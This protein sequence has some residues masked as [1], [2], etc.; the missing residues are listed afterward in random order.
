MGGN[1]CYTTAFV[2]RLRSCSECVSAKRRHGVA[3]SQHCSAMSRQCSLC[4]AMRNLDDFHIHP[5]R[6]GG[7]CQR[8]RAAVDRM[9]RHATAQG[10]YASF[11][12]FSR[13]DRHLRDF[14]ES[15]VDDP[16]FTFAN[17]FGTM[18]SDQSIRARRASQRGDVVVR[19][20]GVAAS[21]TAPP[22]PGSP[23][24]PPIRAEPTPPRLAAGSARDRSCVMPWS[25]MPLPTA[26]GSV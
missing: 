7:R 20:G 12:A 2:R 13:E 15:F 24:G 9:R 16:N 1:A 11:V 3:A 19:R 6:R 5:E 22:P 26:W 17:Y 10:Y 14:M 18:L 4:L 23:A 21:G 8:C 25:C